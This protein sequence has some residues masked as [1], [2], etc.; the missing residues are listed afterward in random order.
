MCSSLDYVYQTKKDAILEIRAKELRVLAN[1]REEKQ[2]D[3]K[4]L[5]LESVGWG[6][7][8]SNDREGPCKGLI[9]Y[10]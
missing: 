3:L 2:H 4:I 7:E 6:K 5:S 1:F 9:D 10:F 8:T